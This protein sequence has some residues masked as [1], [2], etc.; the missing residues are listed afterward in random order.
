MKARKFRITQDVTITGR[1][2]AT[3]EINLRQFLAHIFW[4]ASYSTDKIK[5]S[6]PKVEE[7]GIDKFIRTPKDELKRGFRRQKVWLNGHY[8]ICSV[9]IGAISYDEGVR[10]ARNILS[11]KGSRKE[12]KI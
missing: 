6:K 5:F 8:V 9:P 12:K 11:K 7:I 4:I 10:Q 3:D 2:T 1:E